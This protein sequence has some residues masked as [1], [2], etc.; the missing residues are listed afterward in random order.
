MLE[1]K[2]LEIA[3]LRAMTKVRANHCKR[4]VKKQVSQDMDGLSM[5][6][7]M[8]RKM[9]RITMG[10]MTVNQMLRFSIRDKR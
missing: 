8:T 6:V 2:V 10:R 5:R 1:I 4:G 3:K 9:T 7:P